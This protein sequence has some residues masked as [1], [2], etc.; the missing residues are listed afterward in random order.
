M[1]NEIETYNE[2]RKKM[3]EKSSQFLSE[4]PCELKSLDVA[5]NIAGFEKYARKIEQHW[6]PFGLSLNERG[7]SDGEK[8]CPLWLEILKSVKYSV[9]DT[10]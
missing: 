2:S 7:A 8:L 3:Q 1:W 5:L 9:R 4:Q 10:L 6:R